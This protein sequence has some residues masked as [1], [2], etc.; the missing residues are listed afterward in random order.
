MPLALPAAATAPK[1]EA[2]DDC[3]RTGLLPLTE[4]HARFRHELARQAIEAAL[5]RATAAAL[6]ARV[7]T[8]ATQPGLAPPP[9]AQGLHHADRAGDV[10]TV[11]A[12]AAEAAREAASMRVHREAAAHFAQ[13][14]RNA[15]RLPPEGRTA[16]LEFHACECHLTGEIERAVTDRMSALALRREFGNPLPVSE[17]LRWLSRLYWFL[18]RHPEAMVKAQEAVATLDNTAPGAALGLAMSN[19]SQL[20]MLDNQDLDSVEW[21]AEVLATAEALDLT[22]LKVPA[23]NN[24]GA[25]RL[26]LNDPLGW[27][28]LE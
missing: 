24:V 13:A 6:H 15:S 17:I 28:Q 9:M 27:D 4:D 25:A 22:D 12:H 3:L 7:L 11:R 19:L 18:G 16:L 1:P 23:L 14:L 26:Q 20:F 2:V 8:A 5:P 21:A 10:Q